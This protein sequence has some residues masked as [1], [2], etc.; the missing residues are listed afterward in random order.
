VGATQTPGAR[1][2][3]RLR[4]KARA[5][6]PPALT[7]EGSEVPPALSCR[8]AVLPFPPALTKE[9]RCVRARDAARD[10]LFAGGRL[11]PSSRWTIRASRGRA[12]LYA[13]YARNHAAI[14][15][16]VQASGLGPDFPSQ[17]KIADLVLDV[18]L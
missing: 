11:S 7:K 16:H 8:G 13:A 18:L 10:L 3:Y 9:G 12:P 6:I 5:V 4:K 17:L 15:G 14:R 1:R 2:L